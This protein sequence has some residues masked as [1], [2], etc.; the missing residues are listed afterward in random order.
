LAD[1]TKASVE[2]QLINAG[3]ADAIVEKIVSRLSF[4]PGVSAVSWKI[5]PPS[6]V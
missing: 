4:E 5:A 1:S 2:A 6:G 3:R